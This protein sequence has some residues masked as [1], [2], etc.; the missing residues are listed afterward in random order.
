[1]I[2]TQVYD[3]RMVVTCLIHRVSRV[4]NSNAARFSR[5]AAFGPGM[6]VVDP[7]TV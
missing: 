1:V 2:G 3:A 6:V 7:A 4:L 5:L